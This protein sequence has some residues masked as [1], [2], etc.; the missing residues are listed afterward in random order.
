MILREIT[1]SGFWTPLMWLLALAVA[2]ALALIIYLR[3]E[4]RYKVG[5][6]QEI[7][8]TAAVEYAR[9]KLHV[10]GIHVYWGFT[11]ALKSYYKATIEAH[12]GRV[13][14]YIGWL[15]LVAAVMAVVL[16]LWGG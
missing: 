7:P 13:T 3:A 6:D 12:T 14:D 15:V 11:E 4:S 8:Y 16:L 9:E 10:K 1:P 2:L 5:T